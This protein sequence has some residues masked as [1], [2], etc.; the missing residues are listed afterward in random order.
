MLRLAKVDRRKFPS[1]T[2]QATTEYI[3]IMAA[4]VGLALIVVRNFVKPV[5]EIVITGM[6][7]KIEDTFSKGDALHKLPLKK[8]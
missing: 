3:L 6:E 1:E 4:V 8:R 2:A 5:F 7:K